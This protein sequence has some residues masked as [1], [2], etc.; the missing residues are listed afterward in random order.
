ME[1][2]KSK[3]MKRME[4]G[5]TCVQNAIDQ[6]IDQKFRSHI[7]NI[8]MYISTNGL[9]PTIAFV[10]SKANKSE[11]KATDDSNKKSDAAS[12]KYI[13]KV[14]IDYFNSFIFV[15]EYVTD[16]Q[17]LVDRLFKLSMPAYRKC[18][19][20]ALSMLKWTVKFAEGMIEKEDDDQKSEEQNSQD[21]GSDNH[22]G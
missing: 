5:F 3:K 4:I 10:M 16:L 22:E 1:S 21:N 17:G 15:N 7:K 19:L 8:P 2:L 9:I 11:G 6:G 20:E 18:T 13:G 14:L 12:Y